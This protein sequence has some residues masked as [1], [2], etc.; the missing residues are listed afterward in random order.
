M[1]YKVGDNV[2]V[3]VPLPN[4][5]YTE[6]IS[7][8]ILSVYSKYNGLIAKIVHVYEHTTSYLIDLD[9]SE[10]IWYEDMFEP[11]DYEDNCELDESVYESD[12][13]ISN[14]GVVDLKVVFYQVDNIILSK[15]IQFPNQLGHYAEIYIKNV[16]PLLFTLHGTPTVQLYLSKESV[17]SY[18]LAFTTEGSLYKINYYIAD[19]DNYAALQL[20]SKEQADLILESLKQLIRDFN[21]SRRKEDITIEG[22]GIKL[23]GEIVE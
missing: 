7:Y 18:Y 12:D 19:S 14:E 20:N 21:K 16:D 17:D 6:S 11:L 13:M 8:R 3:K 10:H 5:A 23:Y 15:I 2:R 22:T 1:K 4:D 9:N